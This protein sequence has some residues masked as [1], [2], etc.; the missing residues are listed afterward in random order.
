MKEYQEKR[1]LLKAQL[2]EDIARLQSA[3]DALSYSQDKCETIDL[4]EPLHAEALESLEALTARFARV[5]DILTQKV[6]KTVFLLLQE[7]PGSFIDQT[8]RAEK[9]EIIPD[10]EQLQTI[11]ALRNEIAHEY[12]VE[13]IEDFFAEVLEHTPT[14]KR[15]IKNIVQYAEK[16]QLTAKESPE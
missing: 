8:H 7:P 5:S 1:R 11:R 3:M 4:T 16:H 2:R 6:L 10:A 15:T 12:R 14:L 13:D 9:L